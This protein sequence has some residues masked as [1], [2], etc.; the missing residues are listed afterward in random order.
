MCGKNRW[1]ILLML[2][3]S[4]IACGG[5][6]GGDDDDDDD[7]ENGPGVSDQNGT[8]RVLA[9]NDLGMHCADLDYSTF[10]ILPPFN[11]IHSQVVARG[12]PPRLLDSSEVQL[13]YLATTDP[14]G[15]INSTSQN[16]AGSV[17][18]T[19][20]WSTNPNTGNSFVFDL[21]G[22]DPAPDE[23]LMFEQNMPGI[24]NPY[25]AN[26]PQPFNHY[27]ETKKWFSAEGIPILPI[28]DSGQ[29]NAYPLMRVTAQASSSEDSL[30]SLDVVLPVASEADCQNCHA[31]GEI[32]APTDSEIPFELPDDI[33]DANSVLQAAKQNILLL[34]DAEHATNLVASKPVLC[35]SCHYSAALDLNGSGPSGSQLNQDSM[36]EVMHRHHG[37]LT[38]ESSGEPIFPSD[39]TLQETCYQCHPG[40][41]TQCLRGAMGGAGIGCADCHG[42]MLAV[43][44]EERSPWLDEPRCESCHTGDAT[45][46]LGSSIRLSQAWS[47]D[48]DTATPRIASNKR[49][50]ENDNTLYRNSLGHGGVACEGC[51][52]STHAI[53]PNANPEANDNLA[54]IQL[55][56]HAGTVSD[57]AACHTSLP[58]TLS[59]PHGMHNVNSRGWN[60]NHE[61]FYEADPNSCR[62]CHGTNLQGTVLSQTAADRTYLRDDDGERTI[63]LAKGT[64]VS[65]TLCHEYPEEDD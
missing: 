41:V 49:F 11:V 7:H 62:S 29:L 10:V 55:Q 48:I 59:G 25:S 18:K 56:G 53:W 1:M 61:D 15:S 42:S 33:N 60:L 39:G 23:G 4:L 34:H 24:L 65:C 64:A 13:S 36:S 46:H 9:F 19:N 51:H 40:K 5:G 32:A 37:E 21:F 12:N 30:A 50:A 22:D 31:A 26:D 17:N 43:G 47:D 2:S 38:D 58:L 20:F 14:S 45:S 6:G 54:S 52:G 27:N 57:C 3:L 35:A 28:D 44:R 16:L 8:H 63:S